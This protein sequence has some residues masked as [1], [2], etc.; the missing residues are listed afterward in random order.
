VLLLSI[1][2]KRLVRRQRNS[3]LVGHGAM[4]G[5]H[6]TLEGAPASDDSDRAEWQHDSCDHGLVEMEAERDGLSC[7]EEAHSKRDPEHIVRLL[8]AYAHKK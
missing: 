3:A 5:D 1:G 2:A 8:Y 6:P 4:C 7:D